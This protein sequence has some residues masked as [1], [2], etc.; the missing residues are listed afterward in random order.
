MLLQDLLAVAR[1]LYRSW[2]AKKAS[3]HKLRQLSQ[4]GKK[5]RQALELA[6]MPVATLEHAK[7]WELAEQATEDLGRLVGSEERT[8]T[9]VTAVFDGLE[10]PTQPS[11][12]QARDAERLRQRRLRS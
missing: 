7:A 11:L 4:L 2:R 9:L 1:M 10:R 6:K 12:Y 8:V 5:L 3:Q